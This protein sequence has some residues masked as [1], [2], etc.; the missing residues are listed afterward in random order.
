MH[1]SVRY[2]VSM[3]KAVTRMAVHRCADDTNAN[4]DT[5]WTEHDCKGSLPYEPKSLDFTC[6]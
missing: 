4:K 2:K 6:Y 1:I 5:Q 3:I